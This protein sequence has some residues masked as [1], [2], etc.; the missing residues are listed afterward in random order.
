M[1]HKDEPHLEY[2]GYS[3]V[4][5]GRGIGLIE[6]V[7]LTNIADAAILLQGSKSRAEADHLS[8]QKWYAQFLN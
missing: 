8:L 4:N 5:T 3:R 7:A 6:T 1:K 2:G